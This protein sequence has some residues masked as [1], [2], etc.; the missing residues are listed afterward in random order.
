MWPKI[1]TVASKKD[2]LPR[3]YRYYDKEGTLRRT[4]SFSDIK[5]FDGHKIPTHWVMVPENDKTKKT[6][7]DYKSIKFDV[8]FKPNHFSQKNLTDN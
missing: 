6:I 5:T 1:I 2:C 8:T 7:V 4:L 3:E